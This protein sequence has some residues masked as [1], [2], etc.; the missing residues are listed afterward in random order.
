VRPKLGS[1]DQLLGEWDA[2]KRV[3]K[4][5]AAAVV[6]G[7]SVGTVVSAAGNGGVSEVAA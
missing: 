4:R 6:G 1:N 3:N 7:V 2:A 5:L